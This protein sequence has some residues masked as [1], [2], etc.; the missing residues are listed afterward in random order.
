MPAVPCG[1]VVPV[2]RMAAGL[3][4][5]RTGEEEEEEEEAPTAAAGDPAACSGSRG[6]M[7]RPDKRRIPRGNTRT[8]VQSS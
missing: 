1:L 3:A 7:M 4:E 6:S 5:G 2:A 8:D